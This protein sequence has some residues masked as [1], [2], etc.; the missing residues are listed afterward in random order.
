VAW[1]IRRTD[2]GG[3]WVGHP[4]GR[5]AYVKNKASA[6]RFATRQEAERERCEGNEVLEEVKS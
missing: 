3:G 1:I 5:N 2:Q 4:G 6:R